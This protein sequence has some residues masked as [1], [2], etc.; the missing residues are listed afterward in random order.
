MEI[1]TRLKWIFCSGLIGV[2]AKTKA[3]N[4]EVTRVA[5]AILA[6][7]GLK[8]LLVARILYQNA[9]K[10]QQEVAAA[11]SSGYPEKSGRDEVDE[12]DR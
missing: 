12:V 2:K 11:G 1:L 6:F 10:N 4:F 9:Q 5:L 3:K 8:N 7:F